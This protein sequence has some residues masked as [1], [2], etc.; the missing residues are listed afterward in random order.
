MDKPFGFLVIGLAMFV[1]IGALATSSL[2][3]DESQPRQEHGA[4][5]ADHAAA[6]S[7]SGGSAPQAAANR[8]ANDTP[9]SDIER[10]RYLVEEVAKCPECHTPRNE[11]GELRQEVWLSG[12][13]IWIRPVAPIANWADHAPALAGWPSF[14]EEQGE[15]IL[16]KGTGPEGEELRP[17][18]H[19]YH[20]KH[21]DAKA[22]I[23]YLKS[24]PRS[25]QTY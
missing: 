8:A 20:M 3:P 25:P 5:N 7:P 16:E 18:M 12:A 15:R 23:A 6:N 10:G 24:L 19:I 11:R 9:N 14:T 21:E 13:S 17:P 22:I 2:K 4:T 1:T